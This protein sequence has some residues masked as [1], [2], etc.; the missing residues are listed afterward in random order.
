MTTLQRRLAMLLLF[1]LGAGGSTFS[2]QT[3]VFVRNMKKDA[4]GRQT[5]SVLVFDSQGQI[6][7]PREQD[8]AITEN[9]EKAKIISI[10]CPP[11]KPPINVSSV[12]TIDVSGS[13]KRGGPNITLAI[14]AAK[15]WVDALT[16]SSECAI[17]KFDHQAKVLNGFTTDKRDLLQ[18]MEGLVP[19]GGTN[20]ENALLDPSE[21][22]L[23]LANKGTK[24]RVMVFLTDGHGHVDPN[25]VVAMAT[26]NKVTIYCVSLGLPMPTVLRTISDRT[27]GLYFENVTTV[28]QAIMA[29]RRIYADATGAVGCTVIW[30]PLATCETMKTITMTVAG[31]TW[32]TKQP[33]PEAERIGLTATP[34]ALAFGL[35]TTLTRKIIYTPKG[36]ISTVRSAKVDRSDA[37]TIDAGPLPRTLKKGDTLVV[38]VTRKW[39][40]SS[41]A[42]GRVILDTEPCPV[43]DVYVTAGDPQKLPKRQTLRVVHPNGGEKFRTRSQVP[44]RWEGLPPDVPV[45]LEVSTN[46]G[47]EW[48]TVNE[49]A[50]GLQM[51]WRATKIPSD[52]CLLRVTH[53]Q[54]RA[55]VDTPTVTISGDDFF[56]VLFAPD[57]SSVVTSESTGTPG[58]RTKRP[59]VKMW[60][61]TTGELQKEIGP[62]EYLQYDKD[63]ERLL[64]WDH[65]GLGVYDMP[66]AKELWSRQTVRTPVL[67]ELD[68]SGD[69]ILF[70]GGPGDS[71]VLLNADNGSWIRTFPRSTQQVEW[72]T[73]SQDGKYVAIAEYNGAIKIF[74][75]RNGALMHELRETA[76]SRYFR[77]AFSPD[78]T[79]LAS[80]ASHGTAVLWDVK[81]GSKRRTIAQRRYINDNTYIAFS[82]NGERIAV[83]SNTDQTSI[84]EVATGDHLVAM[85]RRSDVGGASSA[86]FIGNG[87]VMFVGLLTRVSI[88]NAYTGV[89]IAEVRRGSGDPTAPADGSRI[90]VVAEDRSVKIYDLSSPLLQQDVS[91]ALWRLYQPTGE[92]LTVE[93]QPTRLGDA[94]DTLVTIGI[95]NTSND[96]LAV[97]DL[98]I[99]GAHASDFS[100]SSTKD[101]VVPPKSTLPLEFTFHPQVAGQ[102]AAVIVA[103]TDAGKL[104]ARIAGVAVG[105]T[106]S[107]PP[108]TVRRDTVVARDTTPAVV[109][110]PLTDPTTFRSIM[111]PT[112][113]VPKQGTITTGVYDVIGLS[114]GYSVTDNIMVLVGGA[115]PIP[116]RWFGATGYDASWSAAWSIGG[117]YGTHLADDIVVGGGYQ[118]G[119]SY[120][121]QDYSTQLESKITFNALWATAGYGDDDSRLNAYLGYAFKHHVT[122]LEGTFQADAYIVG[123]AYDYR[124]SRHWKICSE[125]FFMRTMS[126]VPITLTARY[127][128]EHDAFEIG[129][130]YVGIAASGAQAADFPLVPMLT[131]VKR[132]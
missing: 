12:L 26:A 123:A 20:F 39:K 43:A 79:T 111:L 132:W 29:Y 120:Y 66:S 48:M 3:S 46:G 115:V 125:A 127:F 17:T 47:Y 35:D 51:I 56:R 68:G 119:Q 117:K 73:I 72:G 118:F 89:Q 45:R 4:Q 5:A 61:A 31:G 99:Q 101:F 97:S 24:R 19:D 41:Y 114:G 92:L 96:T 110:A 27:G 10:D 91:D 1:T 70:C 100:V 15:A 81:S 7:T 50:T 108:D 78:G 90:A 98:Q 116:N 71:T 88:F 38:L 75:A 6:V 80:T 122:Y 25:K 37:F 82:P 106:D 102:R 69:V 22:G 52:S 113:V 105:P 65:Q 64:T 49:Q 8:I 55:Q 40:D 36:G 74:N 94:R 86:G 14:A 85:R 34:A 124:I 60:N 103:E 128:R 87:D 30:E 129:L 44:L 16:D 109:V 18:A 21:G 67:A 130:S 131:W 13:M 54:K 104:S 126:F 57:G 9:G 33:I 83:E 112:A 76:T 121:D 93:F 42:V 77:V 84:A 95:R 59:T 2:Q 53:L 62:G 28:E 23:L 11:S 32:S 107:I 63:G 58:T